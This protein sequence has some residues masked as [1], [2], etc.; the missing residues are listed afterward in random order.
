V[1]PQFHSWLK[2]RPTATNIFHL[3][4][5]I[6]VGLFLLTLR[7]LLLVL[8]VSVFFVKFVFVIYTGDVV[9]KAFWEHSTTQ[10]EI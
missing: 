3:K 10:W 1:T 8:R 9:P 4:L 5:L 7:L 2:T 6:T